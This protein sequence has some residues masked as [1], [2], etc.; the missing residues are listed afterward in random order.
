MDWLAG[1]AENENAGARKTKADKKA[2]SFEI[3]SKREKIERAVYTSKRALCVGIK[4]VNGS[5]I[6]KN[7][8]KVVFKPAD[9]APNREYR[10]AI[11]SKT[12][13]KREAAASIIDEALGYNLV[14]PTTILEHGGQVGS[15]QA[16]VGEAKTAMELKESGRLA[17][18]L[19][20]IPKVEREKFV[21]LDQVLYNTERH[22][23]N[24]MILKDGSA[25]HIVAIDN[26]FSI[27][28][29]HDDNL[30]MPMHEQFT[31]F[32]GGQISGEVM[33]GLLKMKGEEAALRARLEPLLEKNAIDALFLRVQDL[34][35]EGKHGIWR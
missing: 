13:Y 1:K 8:Q 14:P 5:Y 11:K 24:Y 35:A 15:A 20:G 2:E 3:Q 31:E 19:N 33:D 23:K 16:F 6:L 34:I 7:G 22:D 17:E 25:S 4:G 21:A 32:S 29:A 12:Q 18:A 9:E 30:R 28:T 10:R 26:G 27:P